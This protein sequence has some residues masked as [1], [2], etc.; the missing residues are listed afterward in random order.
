MISAIDLCYNR[1]VLY[2]S[3]TGETMARHNRSDPQREARAAN[4]A[5]TLADALHELHIT[6]NELAGILSLNIN[7]VNSWTR[8]TNPALPSGENIERLAMLL[9]RR[10]TGLG[11]RLTTLVA[12]PTQTPLLATER[13]TTRAGEQANLRAPATTFVGRGQQ[14]EEILAL[15]TEVHLLTITGTGGVGKTRLALQVASVAI[16]DFEDGVWVVELG[17]LTVPALVMQAV[18]VALGVRETARISLD[19]LLVERLRDKHLLLVLDNCEHLLAASVTLVAELL[20]ACPTVHI[21]ITSREPLRIPG[22]RVWLAPSL[23]LPDLRQTPSRPQ[24]LR[25][26]ATR[27][28]V[29]RAM[30]ARG[31]FT[32]TEQNAP[33]IAQ[34]CQRL[35]G[36]PLAIELAAAC[37][38][39][40]TL[41]E[42]ATHLNDRFR[43]LAWNQQAALPRHQTLRAAIEWSDNLLSTTERALLYRLAVFAGSWT[44]E[45][46]V[47][48]CGPGVGKQGV[49]VPEVGRL[50]LRLVDKSLVTVHEQKGTI[51]YHLS[52]TIR[53]YALEKGQEQDKTD[54]LSDR[55]LAYF[56]TWAETSA[57]K[58]QSSEQALWLER[59][60][61]EHANLR[62]TL[63]WAMES[64]EV[65]AALRLSAALWR[66]WYAR[67][68]LQEG[69]GWLEQ[70]LAILDFG[71]WILDS[72]AT[73]V[74]QSKIQNLKSKIT[75]QAAA[76]NGAG[77]LAYAQGDYA[78]AQR[79]YAESLDLR[80]QTEDAA[81]IAIALNNLGLVARN[82][83]D[84][85]RASALLEQSITQCRVLGD[86]IG[87][88]YALTSLGEVAR[89]QGDIPRAVMLYEESLLRWQELD[90]QGG[91]AT[92]LH[93]L[94]YMALRQQNTRLALKH[95]RAGLTIFQQHGNQRGLALCLAGLAGAAGQ[96]GQPARA[97][98]LFGA[99]HTLHETIGA[100][101]EPADRADRDQHITF[102]RSQL[103]APTFQINWNEGTLM[104]VEQ[105]VSYANSDA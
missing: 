37:T 104:K 68:Y 93:N 100:S 72:D 79:F 86:A 81:G 74:E 59:I 105:A 52:E 51:R 17:A 30:F 4:F 35:D 10:K 54:T 92:A 89:L 33:L 97:A 78:G 9:E 87:I 14:I 58:L 24:I 103:D 38:D 70:A 11:K 69:R 32:L 77:G 65:E 90:N 49:T 6:H 8:G 16:A 26:E 56:L 28:F 95:F 31:A 73:D 22:E 34:I 84:Y 43:L 2:K 45:A 19:T 55:H 7:T 57:L 83:G 60:E 25:A 42:I 80:E 40:L 44:V 62:A 53:Q 85:A 20:R 82:L 96:M 46:A 99:E 39:S 66:F 15:L 98:R 67:G 47:A 71:F 23:T 36:I 48:I 18:A 75:V 102:V 101:L 50:L 3:V 76:L 1:T 27:L 13:T 12:S 88:A 5:A 21:L 91:M 94:G 63:R 41:D 61:Q 64:H 29:E